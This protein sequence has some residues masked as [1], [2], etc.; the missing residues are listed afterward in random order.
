MN[1]VYDAQNLQ[2]TTKSTMQNKNGMSITF[3]MSDIDIE[4]QILEPCYVE[5]HRKVGRCHAIR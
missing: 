3:V 1:T 5:V 4:S 2:L